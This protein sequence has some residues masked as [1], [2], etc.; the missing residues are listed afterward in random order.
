M[1]E[2]RKATV[3][4]PC[5]RQGSQIRSSIVTAWK[6]AVKNRYADRGSA[7]LQQYL[8]YRRTASHEVQG[9]TGQPV[10]VKRGI[11]DALAD[12]AR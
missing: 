5:Q 2:R 7:G 6:W 9:Q 12:P 8:R 1:T 3:K 11:D 10:P 4:R